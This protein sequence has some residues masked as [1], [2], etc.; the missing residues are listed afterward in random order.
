M[1]TVKSGEEPLLLSK[2]T[3][4]DYWLY[5]DKFLSNSIDLMK[6]L[7]SS[8]TVVAKFPLAAAVDISRAWKMASSTASQQKCNNKETFIRVHT[9]HSVGFE[10]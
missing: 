9:V 7:L 1:K 8:T 4:M 10:N 6:H 5:C 3:F 2:R